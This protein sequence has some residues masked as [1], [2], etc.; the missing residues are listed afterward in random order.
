MV[1]NGENVSSKV[2]KAKTDIE[3]EYTNRHRRQSAGERRP[4]GPERRQFRDGEL[5]KRSEVVEFADAIDQYKLV[6]RRRFVTFD[7]IFDVLLELG[8]HK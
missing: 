5:S 4:N 7:E 8:Y 2:E 1:E 3:Y 6:N